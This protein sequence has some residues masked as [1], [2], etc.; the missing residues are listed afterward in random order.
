[1]VG[2]R[3]AASSSKAQSMWGGCAWLHRMPSSWRSARR[4]SC[5]HRLR[6]SEG[7]CLWHPGKW[8]G[9]P[10]PSV[11]LARQLCLLAM[12]LPAGPGPSENS[13]HTTGT[14]LVIT[15]PVWPLRPDSLCAPPVFLG[16]VK[17]QALLRNR[18]AWFS[19]AEQTGQT[20]VSWMDSLGP[21]KFPGV[22]QATCDGGRSM[23][24][25]PLP[26]LALGD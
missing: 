22:G 16:P 24:P 10:E 2:W 5:H 8:A 14:T 3:P 4:S 20:R 19:T 7:F 17:G 9:H 11:P 18:E 1:M 12:S 13:L 6:R 15:A 21:R 26:A 23:Q 25:R